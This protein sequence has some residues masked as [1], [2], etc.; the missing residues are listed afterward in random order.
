[1]FL[2]FKTQNF[3]NYLNI[4][5]PLPLSLNLPCNIPYLPYPSDTTMLKFTGYDDAIIGV[6]DSW[7]PE[8]KLVYSGEKLLSLLISEGMTEEEAVEWCSFN[9]E[10]AYMGEA[11]PLVLWP[12]EEN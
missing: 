8:P 9:M 7:L 5:P 6:T 3:P 4:R 11:T 1:M 2:T 10:G 12:Y